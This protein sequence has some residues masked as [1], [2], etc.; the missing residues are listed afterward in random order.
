MG[1]YPKNFHVLFQSNRPDSCFGTRRVHLPL[2]N[3]YIIICFLCLVPEFP[4]NGQELNGAPAKTTST[5]QESRGNEEG[6]KQSLKKDKELPPVL[7]NKVVSF[8][9]SA[10]VFENRGENGW[11]EVWHKDS[12]KNAIPGQPMSIKLVGTNLVV[13]VQFTP[14]LK[15]NETGILVAQAQVWIEDENHNMRYQTTLH[16]IPLKFGE[17]IYYFPLGEQEPEG[18]NSIEICLEMSPYNERELLS[19][20][21]EPALSE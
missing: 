6:D 19:S 20:H 2:K 13:I 10:R 17:E 16:S 4:L 9:I 1:I 5:A 3:F 12:V 7:Q 18:I 21:L 8:H 11:S 15:R 14:Y